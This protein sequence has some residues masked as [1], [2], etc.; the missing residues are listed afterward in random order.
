MTD[1]ELG[2]LLGPHPSL[3]YPITLF[4]ADSASAECSA[5]TIGP[6]P[7]ESRFSF[8]GQ[9]GQGGWRNLGSVYFNCD[10]VAAAACNEG[11]RDNVEVRKAVKNPEQDTRVFPRLLRPIAH[12]RRFTKRT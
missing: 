3:S 12:R 8:F 9:C 10:L 4:N 6:Q 11:I 5:T 7:D 1:P 2:N